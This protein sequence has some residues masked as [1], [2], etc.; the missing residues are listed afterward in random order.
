MKKVLAAGVCLFSSFSLWAQ[1]PTGSATPDPA[2]LPYRATATKVNDL[3]HTKLDV[4]FDYAKSYLYGKAWVTLKPHAYATDSLRLDAQGMDIKTVAL[5][6]SNGSQQPLKYDYNQQHL[7]IQLGKTVD[8][9]TPYTVY[10]EYTAKPNELKVKGSAAINDA[11]GLY[12]INPD[13]TVKGK[14]VQIWTQGES[15]SNSAWFPT[16]DRPNQKMTTEISMTVPSKYLT[17][18]NGKMVSQTPAGAGLRTDTWK[19]EQPHSPYLVMMT[20]GSFKVTHDTWRNKPIDYYL[21]PTYAPYAKQ[22][23]GN[24][25]EMLEF[26]STRLGVEFPWNKYAQIVVRDYVSGAME[27][28]TA[29]LH[30]DFLQKTP[31]ELID[32]QYGND[33][34]VIAHELF[35]QWFGDYVTTESWSNLTVNESMADFSEG[36][37]AEH[38]YGQDAADAHKYGYLN[39]YLGNPENYTK[40]LVRFHYAEREDMFDAVTYQ[41]GG[42]ILDMLRAYLGDEVFFAGLNQ[43]LKQNAFGNGEAH[44]MRLAFEAA[45]GKDLNWFYN[46]W[47]FNAGQPTVTIDYAWDAARKVQTVTIKQLQPGEPFTLPIA[48]DLY[49]K[50]KV[51]RR[52]V[53]LRN[54]TETLEFPVAAKP[55]LVNVDA[56]KVLLWQKKDNKP[57]ADYVYQYQ[58]APRYVDRYEAIAAAKEQQATNAAARNMLVAATADKYYGLRI[59]ALQA[60]DLE[61]KAMQKA[62]APALRKQLTTE[63]ET[64]VQAEILTDLGQLADKRD[65]ALFTSSLKSQSY[66][67]Q[68]AALSGLAAVA[69]AKA[70][71]LAKTFEADN[72]GKLTAAIAEVYA[73]Q[74]GLE[75]WPFVRQKFDEAGPQ[76]RFD[77]LKGFAGMLMRLNDPTAV[78]EGVDRIKN[79]G[80]QFKS[81]GAADPMINLLEALKSKQSGTAAAQNKQVIERAQ[82]EIQQAK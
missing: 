20:V 37:W 16:I 74:G 40:N 35:H 36:L 73:T 68:G 5:V 50:G 76:G 10:L 13:S 77:L 2:L 63:K 56:Q 32:R 31:R 54:A 14:P 12:F 64:L 23:F 33:E 11:K 4:R 67:V 61:N 29:T 8:P 1:A 22:I 58:H 47:F 66:A 9:G 69:P 18:S 19:M 80:I 21:E 46:Q 41:K 48:I 26:F 71:P 60:L 57:F 79:L 7:L 34:S 78:A 39:Q 53:L 15:Q 52:N 25:P 75:Q 65:E 45:S 72:K 59:E 6:G 44:Q 43:Y 42:L 24:T 28:T 49:V 55:D 51:E 30:G 81:Y 62:V 27:N 3:V 82:Q 70:L 38:K 17:L